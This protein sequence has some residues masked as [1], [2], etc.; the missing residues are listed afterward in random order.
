[1]TR[2]F[3]PFRFL[4]KTVVSYLGRGGKQVPL[5]LLLRRQFRGRLY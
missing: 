5:F 3:D 1:M 4:G 2:V